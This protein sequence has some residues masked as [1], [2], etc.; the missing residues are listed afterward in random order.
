MRTH[1]LIFMLF[2]LSLAPVVAMA[3]PNA[4]NQA[5]NPG[6]LPNPAPRVGPLS[7]C[8]YPLTLDIP[9]NN[10]V[11]VVSPADS[12]VFTN[13]RVVFSVSDDDTVRING[14]ALMPLPVPPE[15]ESTYQ[16]L[17]ENVPMAAALH[18]RGRTWRQASASVDSA[19]LAVTAAA[20]DHYSQILQATGS[21][22]SATVGALNFL[23][24]DSLVDSSRTRLWPG[25]QA[26]VALYF[27]GGHAKWLTPLDHVFGGRPHPSISQSACS[28]ISDFIG[29]FADSSYHIA[30]LV[31]G[32]GYMT[33]PPPGAR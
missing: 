33:V 12:L 21:V 26:A 32:R 30:F 9:A 11:I 24:Q 3:G 13:T 31:K 1:T 25:R 15:P 20:R 19:R 28:M 18:S 7:P 4:G 2:A 5:N 10:Y 6:S 8:S 29:A 17:L 14:H 27:R 23:K 16:R 22:S